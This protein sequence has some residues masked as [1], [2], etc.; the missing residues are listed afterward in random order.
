MARTKRTTNL[1][2]SPPPKEIEVY[3]GC[4]NCHSSYQPSPTPQWAP[5]P[6]QAHEGSQSRAA[7]DALL[8]ILDSAETKRGT[9][10]GPTPP[11]IHEVASTTM[12]LADS[13]SALE[14]DSELAR[15]LVKV[16]KVR[17]RLQELHPKMVDID[18]FPLERAL[19]AQDLKKAEEKRD[20]ARS[21]RRERDDIRRAYYQDI[22]FR[23]QPDE[24][25][26]LSNFVLH[27][28]NQIPQLLGLAEEYRRRYPTGWLDNTQPLHSISTILLSL[29]LRA[30]VLLF[31]IYKTFVLPRSG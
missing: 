18:H 27:Y 9:K 20:A 5:I 7:Y 14:L 3:R 17:K 15:K 8:R 31:F 12:A 1:K 2:P 28:Q 25:A 26:V 29:G 11:V 30:F 10:L 21:T 22:P 13:E 4:E 19:I 16:D 6:V 23:C 24:A